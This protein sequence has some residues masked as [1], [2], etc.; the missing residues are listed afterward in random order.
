MAERILICRPDHL[1]DVLLTLPAVVALRAAFP[2]AYIG[3]VLDCSTADVA[4]RC[5][6]IDE[7]FALPFPPLTHLDAGADWALAVTDTVKDLR[8]RY[9]VVILS[10]TEAAAELLSP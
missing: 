7:R 9:D 1:C 10:R 6:D 5:P 4:S 3:L 2:G 8:G